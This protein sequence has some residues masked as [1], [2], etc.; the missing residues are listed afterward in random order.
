MSARDKAAPVIEIK[1]VT[2]AFGA[3]VVASNLNL[4]VHKGEIVALLG[5]TGAGK[6]TVLN[7]IMG[8]LSC[9]SGSIRVATYDPYTA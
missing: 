8:N 9:N 2:K 4:V 6:S 7:M 3:F 5:R 1:G